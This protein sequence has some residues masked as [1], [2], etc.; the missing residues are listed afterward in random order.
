M[1]SVVTPFLQIVIMFSIVMLNVVAPF[2]Q[3]VIMFSIVMVNVVAPLQQQSSEANAIKLCTAV[4]CD[5][6]SLSSLVQCLRVS[7]GA[8]PRVERMKG[9]SLG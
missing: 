5:F 2:M 8:Y 1:L 6:S 4:S 9:A 7:P 3:I